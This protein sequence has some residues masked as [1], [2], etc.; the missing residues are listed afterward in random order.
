MKQGKEQR[1][2]EEEP[3]Q[4]IRVSPLGKTWI[5]DIDGT[6]VKHNGYKIDGKDTLLE[7]AGEFFRN[8]SKEDMVVLITSRT[9]EYREATEEFL[10]AN[11]IPFDYII[12]HAPMG[13]RILV[14]D[15]K[16]SGLK[17]AVSVST[18]RDEFMRTKFEVDENM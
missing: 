7:G 14:N 11:H 8:V 1:N 10:K 16:P 18:R 5:F 9:E 2:R 15:A 13:E 12:Y 6:I 4:T 3:E 17:T